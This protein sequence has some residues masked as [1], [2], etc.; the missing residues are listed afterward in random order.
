MGVT[1]VN[2]TSNSSSWTARR[3]GPI[4]RLARLALVGVFIAT[5]LSVIGPR[6]SAQFR[7]SHILSEP[8]A[9]FLHTAMFVTFVILVGALAS[10]LAGARVGRRWQIGAVVVSV[11][12]VASAAVIGVASEGAVWGFP[13]ADLV[14]SFDVLNLVQLTAAEVLAV[15]L[16]TPGCE[17]G[18][19]S[20]LLA[21]A[22]RGTARSEDVLACI[23][24]L[25]L[26]DAWEDKRR[27]PIQV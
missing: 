10:S 11:A 22:G 4:G 12:A 25:H 21:G 26:V 8:L 24:G 5:L 19:W 13:L 18:V 7:N 6:G 2:A 3:T 9:W 14:W 1:Q 27:T 23:V 16:G 15:A 20:E 17:I